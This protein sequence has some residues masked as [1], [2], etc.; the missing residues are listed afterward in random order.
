[1]NK[2]LISIFLMAFCLNACMKTSPLKTV[3]GLYKPTEIKKSKPNEET[4]LENKIL[5]YSIFEKENLPLP[6]NNFGK[7]IEYLIPVNDNEKISFKIFENYDEEKVLNFYKNISLTAY[8]DNSKYFRWKTTINKKDLYNN[9]EKN[10]VN[11]SKSNS[12]NTFILENEKWISK[13]INSIGDIKEVKVAARGSSGLITHL[14]LITSKGKYLIAKEYNMRRLFATNN[15]LFGAKGGSK[16]YEKN[17]ITKCVTILPSAYFAFEENGTKINIYGGGYGHG[18]GM[19]QYAAFDLSKSGNDYIDILKRYYKNVDIVDME[20][21][22]GKNKNI[23]IGLTTANNLYL[24]N[25]NIITS[26]ELKI[27]SDDLKLNLGTNQKVNVSCKNNKIYITLLN[28][29]KYSTNSAL[30]FDANGYFLTLT[31]LIK[32]HTSSPRYRGKIT[33][34]PENNNFRV[35]NEL[36]IEDYLLQVVPSEMP[37]SFGVEALKA[38]AVAARTYAISDFLKERYINLGFHVKDTIESQVYN[39][40]VENDDATEAVLKT[41][42]KIMIYNGVPIDAKYFST[43]SGFTSFANDIW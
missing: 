21:V 26:G 41:K 25:L 37:R 34:I 40:Q 32:T 20:E 17:P 23:K 27:N 43:S 12:K 36:N 9:I 10:F 7:H 11:I 19:P 29:K 28:G 14:L 22:L 1:M 30:T 8:G 2:K 3:K 31:P 33:I 39:N 35:I 18:A 6:P 24:K 15:E 13:K 38:Q 5:K 4:P 42:G 16:E